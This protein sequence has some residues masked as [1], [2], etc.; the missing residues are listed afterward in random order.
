MKKFIA[1]FFMACVGSFS[2][3]NPMQAL[4]NTYGSGSFGNSTYGNGSFTTTNSSPVASVSNAFSAFFCTDQAPP[5]APMLY[6]IDIKGDSAKLYFAPA[7]GPYNKYFVAFGQNL[8]SEGYGAEYDTGMVKGAVTYQVN[9]L[10]ANTFYTFKVRAGNGCKPG[11]WSNTLTIKTQSK[12]S[13]YV[14]KYFVRSQA[15][16]I[17]PKIYGAKKH[18]K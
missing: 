15:K 5:T 18:M 8:N 16:Y 11:P 3:L 4:A 17:A 13:R 2:L 12:G 1:M 10:G 7:A 14:T 6:Q 9:K